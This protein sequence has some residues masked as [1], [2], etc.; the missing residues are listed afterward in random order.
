[1]KITGVKEKEK[2]G[3]DL[4]FLSTTCPKALLPASPLQSRNP[5]TDFL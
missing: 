3:Y 2:E 4:T 5:Q 1:L